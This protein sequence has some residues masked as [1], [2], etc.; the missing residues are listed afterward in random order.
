M[1]SITEKK[2]RIVVSDVRNNAPEK[3]TPGSKNSWDHIGTI[4]DFNVGTLL[5]RIIGTML[6]FTTFSQGTRYW[7]SI[8]GH[9][10]ELMLGH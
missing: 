7:D 6:K 10:W 8:S 3:A 1:R 9:Y 4:L 5:G 2:N